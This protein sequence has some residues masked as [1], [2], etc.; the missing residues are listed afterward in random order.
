[1]LDDDIR[2]RVV[3]CRFE[4]YL[5]SFPA[6]C[7]VMAALLGHDSTLL[8]CYGCFTL[9][10]SGKLT[11]AERLH[12]MWKR[13]IDSTLQFAHGWAPASLPLQCT[14]AQLLQVPWPATPA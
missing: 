6:S 7:E 2:W 14:V 12:G 13:A 5:E 1:M 8:I 11:E 3:T 4:L 10:T 9:S